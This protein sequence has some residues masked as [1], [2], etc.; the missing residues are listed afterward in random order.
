MARLKNNRALFGCEVFEHFGGI[1]I[2]L[3][4][5]FAVLYMNMCLPINAFELSGH[6]KICD[7]II[8]GL[9]LENRIP[10]NC[11]QVF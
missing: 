8:F 10:R 2:P 4:A 3:V 1:R 7:I 6:L 9:L 11:P 5:N